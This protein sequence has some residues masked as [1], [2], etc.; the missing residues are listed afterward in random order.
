MTRLCHPWAIRSPRRG[1]TATFDRL[2]TDWPHT[3]YRWL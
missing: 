3:F 1:C 2:L